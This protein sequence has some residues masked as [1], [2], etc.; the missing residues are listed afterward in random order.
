L[1]GFAS[2]SPP[3]QQ[4][5][6]SRQFSIPIAVL[7]SSYLCFSHLPHLPRRHLSFLFV[8][9]T[10]SIIH[11]NQQKKLSS[12]FSLLA[13]VLFCCIL[14]FPFLPHQI[15]TYQFLRTRRRCFCFA[16]SLADSHCFSFHLYFKCLRPLILPS[17]RFYYT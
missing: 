1:E 2:P 3:Q 9:G 7:G 17:R 13:G 5:T 12:S 15:I 8:L 14:L 16:I 10:H 4:S 6:C 11:P